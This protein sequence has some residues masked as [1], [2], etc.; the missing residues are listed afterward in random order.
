MQLES[1]IEIVEKHFPDAVAMGVLPLGGTR[2]IKFLKLE[3]E[4]TEQ[5][6]RKMGTYEDAVV[7]LARHYLALV[8]EQR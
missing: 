7:D 2:P 6:F 8:E 3:I 1:P 4:A 5:V